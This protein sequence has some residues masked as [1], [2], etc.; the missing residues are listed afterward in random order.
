MPDRVAPALSARD[1]S[2]RVN[3][4]GGFKIEVSA[5]EQTWLSIVSDGRR[6]YSGILQAEQSKILECRQSALIKTGNAGGVDVVF[7]GKEIGTLGRKGQIR[8]VVFTKDNY[9]IVESSE[10]VLLN[11]FALASFKRT[12]E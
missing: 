8:T 6:I 7:N 11:G 5:L 10:H 12:V 2:A 3:A 9:E 1:G 4:A